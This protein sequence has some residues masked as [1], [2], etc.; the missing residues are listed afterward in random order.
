MPDNA[1]LQEFRDEISQPSPVLV[2]HLT[3]HKA[4]LV[5][6]APTDYGLIHQQGLFL[7]WQHDK[8]GERGSGWD[9]Y[10]TIY[11]PAY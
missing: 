2:F 5:T 1:V 3:D 7:I 9:L 4:E 6:S 11:S 10:F 8:Q